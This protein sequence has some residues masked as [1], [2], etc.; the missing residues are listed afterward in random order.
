MT[1]KTASLESVKK[2]WNQSPLFSHELQELGSE[3][4]FERID[5]IKKTDVE[6]FTFNKWEFEHFQDKDVLEVGCGPGWYAINYA[7][8][9]ARVT[10][11]DLSENSIEIARKHAD[12]RKVSVDFQVGNAEALVFENESFDF[13]LASGVLHHTPD[14]QRAFGECFRV[15]KKG[16]RAKISMYHKGFLHRPLVFATLMKLMALTGVRHPG[17]DFSRTAKTPD[18]FIRQYDGKDNP[19]GVGKTREAW[20]QMLEKAGFQVVSSFLYYIPFRF[21]PFGRFIP[22]V[23]HDFLQRRFGT[24]I[25]FDLQKT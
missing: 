22:G 17:A 25:C 11:V 19:V 2:Y 10:A 9:G 3:A 4:F 18:E 7:L 15:L 12:Y 23:L 1:E 24:I 21:F 14:S 6:R 5:H 16:G 13:L 8:R 20:R